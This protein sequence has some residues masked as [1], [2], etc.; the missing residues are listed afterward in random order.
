EEKVAMVR[1]SADGKVASFDPASGFIPFPGGSKK[2]AIRF[3]DKSGRYWTLSNVIPE[4][5][6]KQ[7]P[8]RNAASFRN[9]LALMSSADLLHWQIHEVIRQHPD[10]IN[11]GFQYVDWLI[12]GEDMI[13]ASRTAYDDG[14]EGANNNHDA[15]FL[16][17]HSIEGF[18][19][20]VTQAL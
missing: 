15:N 19:K 7:Y 6:R 16:T 1:I 17:F 11:H 12:D 20:K 8:G 9:T 14:K 2:F 13:V 10:V 18:R 3:D 5:F 4:A